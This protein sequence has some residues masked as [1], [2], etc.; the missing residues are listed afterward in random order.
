AWAWGR[1]VGVGGGGVGGAAAARLPGEA[2][3][4][5]VVL[6]ARD[7][8]GGRTWY[9]ELPGAGISVEYGG[10]FFSRATQPRIA[11]EIERYGLP[12]TPMPVPEVVA[13][14]RGSSRVEGAPAIERLLAGLK[15]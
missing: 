8:I 15:A 7:R 9:R 11:A 14:I 12:V 2:G 10:M 4:R 1:R 3:R 5:V 13:W 6:E